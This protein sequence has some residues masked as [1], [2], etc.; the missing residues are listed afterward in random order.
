LDWMEMLVLVDTGVI[1]SFG[2]E[3]LWDLADFA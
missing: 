3:K 1:G 2:G